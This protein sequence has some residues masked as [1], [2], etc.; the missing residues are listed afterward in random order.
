MNTEWR[1][2]GAF[3]SEDFPIH[4]IFDRRHNTMINSLSVTFP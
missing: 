3:E 4:D 2:L 1:A